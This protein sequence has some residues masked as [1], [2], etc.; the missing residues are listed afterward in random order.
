MSP[1]PSGEAELR[2]GPRRGPRTVV[3]PGA[4]TPTAGQPTPPAAQRRPGHAC[5][6]RPSGS[7]PTQRQA[8]LPLRP[9]KARELGIGASSV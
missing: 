1:W 2:C 6:P 4:V 3:T 8:L 9:S 5:T 7:L